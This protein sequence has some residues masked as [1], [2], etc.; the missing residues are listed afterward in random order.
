MYGKS[1]IIGYCHNSKAIHVVVDGTG[2]IITIGVFENEDKP[3]LAKIIPRGQNP[4]SAIEE[5][6]AEFRRL[7]QQH[8]G[9]HSSEI[10]LS[11]E[12]TYPHPSQYKYIFIENSITLGQLT[13]KIRNQIRKLARGD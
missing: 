7:T 3:T 10:Y 2:D 6:I 12:R 5:T 9:V 1:E 13:R 8:G 11:E 4:S